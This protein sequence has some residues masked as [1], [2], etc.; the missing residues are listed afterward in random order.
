MPSWL[1]PLYTNE[2]SATFALCWTI[3]KTGWIPR[4]HSLAELHASVSRDTLTDSA[5]F[6]RA[7][8]MTVISSQSSP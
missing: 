2:V 7:N 3:W 6:E 8:Y 4:I 1:F 5:A